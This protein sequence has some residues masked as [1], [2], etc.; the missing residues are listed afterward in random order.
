MV[1][2]AGRINEFRLDDLLILPQIPTQIFPESNVS[3]VGTLRRPV[4]PVW[5]GLANAS[6]AWATIDRTRNIIFFMIVLMN[7]ARS[8]IV[9]C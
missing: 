1:R 7:M 6:V 9:D 5:V 3:A 4:T 8:R 2:V